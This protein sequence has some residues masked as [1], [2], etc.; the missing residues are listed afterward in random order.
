MILIYKYTN[1]TPTHIL[2]SQTKN[3]HNNKLKTK[4]EKST[5]E[6]CSKWYV[7]IST[8]ILRI[9]KKVDYEGNFIYLLF[10]EKYAFLQDTGPVENCHLYHIHISYITCITIPH[11]S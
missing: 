5:K 11:L 10:G 8:Y 6:E 2:H 7:I 3:S 9:S 4:K 1:A